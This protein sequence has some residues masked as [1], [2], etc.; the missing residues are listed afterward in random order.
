M[1]GWQNQY[2]KDRRTDKKT[3]RTD[4][5]ERRI[6]RANA[7]ASIAWTTNTSTACTQKE[8]HR[9]HCGPDKGIDY[10]WIP[11]KYKKA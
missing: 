10:Q 4:R 1:R 5:E 6:D 2:R 3:G 7:V 9:I 8:A 11:D